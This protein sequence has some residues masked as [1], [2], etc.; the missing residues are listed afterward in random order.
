MTSLPSKLESFIKMM[1]EGEEYARHGF[2]LLSKRS[3]PEDYFDALAE[4]GFFEPSR[5]PTP[6]PSTEPGFVQI[7]F[8]TA[9]NYL[10]AVAKRTGE[11]NDIETANKVMDV[12]RKVSAFR[13]PNGEVQDNSTTY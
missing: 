6:V 12:I 9:L 7:P 8:W 5:N 1:N 10:E 13:G 2:D 4:S 11:Q 3:K